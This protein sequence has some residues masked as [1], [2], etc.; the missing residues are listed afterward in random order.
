MLPC[1]C[2]FVIVNTMLWLCRISKCRS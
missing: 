2:D 1:W